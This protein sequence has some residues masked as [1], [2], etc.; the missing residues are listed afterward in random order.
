MRQISN[1]ELLLWKGLVQGFGTACIH[2]GYVGL[3]H[4]DRL[5]T[6]SISD[7][8][9]SIKISLKKQPKIR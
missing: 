6:A 9:A 4:I 1:C 5:L 3:Q 2:V 8:I 7:Q